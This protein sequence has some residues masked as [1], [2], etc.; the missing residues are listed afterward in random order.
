MIFSPL[1]I[2]IV[3]RDVMSTQMSNEFQ[4]SQP[5]ITDNQ[6]KSLSLE[7]LRYILNQ[8]KKNNKE[9]L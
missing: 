2:I 7:Q 5:F 4:G 9:K 8:K 6:Y 3:L 1:N